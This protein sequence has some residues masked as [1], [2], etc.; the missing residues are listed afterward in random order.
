MSASLDREGWI[1]M[2]ERMAEALPPTGQAV[3]VCLIGSAACLL[4]AMPGRASRD[5][6]VWQP[7]SDFDRL[8][9]Q[10]AAE[11]AGLLFDPHVSLEPD[12]PYLQIVTPGPSQ[13][14]T[15]TP[16]LWARLGR[17][18]IY[19]PPWPSLVASKLVRGDERDVEDIL[20][21]AG[22][23]GVTAEAVQACAET[24][25]EPARQ[26]VLENLIYLRI[27]KL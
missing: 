13:A 27:M 14:G 11:A 19:L 4:D 21:L 23:H 1:R 12:R 16:E 2:L 15:F 6:D 24:M 10:R 9:L 20:F 22:K 26:Q 25:P 5:L 18:E 8:E 17:L 7:A 3:R